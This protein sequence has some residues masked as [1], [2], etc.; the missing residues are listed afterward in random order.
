M[1][2]VFLIKIFHIFRWAL[3]AVSLN[4]FEGE[5]GGIIREYG[6]ENT[7][8]EASI[9]YQIIYALGLIFIFY[10]TLTY[11]QFNK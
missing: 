10:L 7:N 4:Q 9:L 8:K 11:S 1:I 3:Q 5:D 6:Y 2:I